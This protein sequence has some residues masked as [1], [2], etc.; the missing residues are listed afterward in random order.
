MNAS[1]HCPVCEEGLL[2]AV[3][4]EDTFAHDGRNVRVQGLEGYRC[5]NCDA[6]PIFP[7][8]IR[9]NQRRISDAKR[10]AYGLLSA[11]E[12][13]AIRESLELSQQ[14]AAQ[15]FGGGVNAF[16]KYERGQT[17]QS[18]PMDRLLRLVGAHPWLLDFLRIQAG[19]EP[20]A[21]AVN[22][23]VD[24]PQAV[25]LN[26]PLYTSRPVRGTLVVSSQK[27]ESTVVSITDRLKRKVA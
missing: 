22:G 11:A 16:S 21:V 7:D 10:Q 26:D 4:F 3:Q 13:L 25:S 24:E 15:I 5:S 23:Y 17:V 12:V 9:R 18:V 20:A 1:L 2:T 8:Q 6:A 19:L 27:C 14:D